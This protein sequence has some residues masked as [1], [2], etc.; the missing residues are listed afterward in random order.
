M[1]KLQKSAYARTTATVLAHLDYAALAKGF[2]V[3]YNEIKC[4]DDLEAAVRGSLCQEGPVLTRIVADYGKRPV[5]WIDAVRKRYTNELT[6]R[7]KARF[8]AR[9]G[10]RAAQLNKEND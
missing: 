7:Q 1:Q 9:A 4:E 10:V 5:R 3:G 6:P 2:G 8:V